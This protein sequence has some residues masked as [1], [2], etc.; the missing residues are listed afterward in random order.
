MNFVQALKQAGRRC[1]AAIGL[2]LLAASAAFAHGERAQEPYLRTR[3]V[4]F[5]DVQYDK[6]KIAVN[7]QFTVVGKFRLMQD[8]PDA[9]S[10]PDIV[11]LSTYSPGPMVTRVASYL[12]G[13]PARQSFAKLELGRD[14]D[15][16]VVLKGRVPGRYHIH[17]MLSIKGSGPLAGPGQ[18]I[19]ITG[20]K[21]DFREPVTTMTGV[22]VDNLETYGTRRA[23]GWYA[24]WIVL[25]AFWLLF[26]LVRPLLIP[27]W[28]AL[29]KG[30]EDVL[31]TGRDLAVGIALGVVVV[32]ISFGGYAYATKQYPYVVP[33]QAGTNKV[34]P[35]P[36]G[37]SDVEV[38]VTK[39]TYDVPGRSMRIVA[40]ITNKGEEPLSIL[41]F[42]TANVR[43][44][45]QQLP[46]A[47]GAV[48]ASFPMDLVARG[49]LVL[50]DGRPIQPGET[51]EVKIDATDAMWERERLVSFLTDVDSKFGG[52]LF[53]V[54][55][56]GERQHT[57][58][59]GPILPVFT[60]I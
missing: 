1:A 25:A 7:E 10:L 49:G 29:Q 38:K 22:Q 20:S 2:G 8:W 42:T 55:A 51:R 18:W 40:Q 11:F 31:V 54:N 9:V 44:I 39:S 28:I 12:N 45:N 35:L 30:R 52:L 17:P 33:L 57:E 58:I 14:Y 34:D 46:A 37:R 3:T 59:G 41:E 60:E 47:A 21:A 4:Q 16:K 32:A 6:G 26:W 43:F 53:F 36:R 56:S 19:E 15:F 5:Y 48:Q 24:L 27:R 23:L 13:A 50:S